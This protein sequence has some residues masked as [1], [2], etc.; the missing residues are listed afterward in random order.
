MGCSIDFLLATKTFFIG[1]AMQGESF[2]FH[3]LRTDL[4][5]MKV[6]PIVGEIV[7]PEKVYLI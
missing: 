7:K 5:T 4:R 6:D 1:Y 2:T 3:G